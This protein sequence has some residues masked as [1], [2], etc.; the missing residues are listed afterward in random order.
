MILDIESKNEEIFEKMIRLISEGRKD[1][2]MNLFSSVRLKRVAKSIFTHVTKTNVVKDGIPQIVFHDD[3]YIVVVSHVGY[4]GNKVPFPGIWVLGKEDN[5]LWIHRASEGSVENILEEI[6]FEPASKIGRPMKMGIN[7]MTKERVKK[8]ILGYDYDYKTNPHFEVGKRVRVQGDLTCERTCVIDE[9]LINEHLQ[10]KINSSKHYVPDSYSDAVERE[11]REKILREKPLLREEVAD[12]NRTLNAGRD[13][14]RGGKN[15]EELAYLHHDFPGDGFYQH[16][17]SPADCLRRLVKSAVYEYINS[18]EGKQ[19][20]QNELLE[21]EGRGRS[22]MAALLSD[23]NQTQATAR[24]S[25]HMIIVEKALKWKIEPYI[26]EHIEIMQKTTAFL[27]HDEHGTQKIELEPGF[28]EFR[29]L[30][31]HELG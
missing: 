1:E 10:E 4:T 24:V 27:I 21:A 15:T 28:Y 12:Y 14:R 29:L 8:E 22:E 5:M 13:R 7:D 26:S 25:N 9:K 3:E 16:T 18:E 2:F 20:L 23:E 30:P 17:T 6:T 31:R 19:R 11:M